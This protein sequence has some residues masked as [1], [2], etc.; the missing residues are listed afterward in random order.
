MTWTSETS[1]PEDVA[2]ERAW[3][4]LNKALDRRVRVSVQMRVAGLRA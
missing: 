1:R 3:D 2:L 4:T